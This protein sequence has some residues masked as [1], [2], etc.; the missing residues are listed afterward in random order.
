MRPR[1]L[2]GLF[3]EPRYPFLAIPPE[4]TVSVEVSP[5]RTGASAGPKDVAFRGSRPSPKA[6]NRVAKDVVVSNAKL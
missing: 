2:A 1:H 6:R 5:I 3:E 4:K